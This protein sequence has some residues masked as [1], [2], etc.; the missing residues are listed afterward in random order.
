MRIKT[1]ITLPEEL[2]RRLDRIDS[3]RSA[4]LE[5][6]AAAYLAHLERQ[7]RDRRDVEI[8]NR[9]AARLNREAKDTLERLRVQL[10]EAQQ[11]SAVP[12]FTVSFGVADSSTG[13]TV[14]E[15]LRHADGA[16]TRGA[17][18][19]EDR[20]AAS[21]LPILGPWREPIETVHGLVSGRPFAEVS[22]QNFDLIMGLNV[23]AAYFAA[24]AVANAGRGGQAR[25]R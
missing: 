8:I 12:R 3:N 2:L 5:R 14:E 15:V 25:L 24:Q 19:L 20:A 4:L 7:Q 10:A 6:A 17:K 21:A 11:G 16:L 9:N 18:E 23:R 1:S 22:L 13:H